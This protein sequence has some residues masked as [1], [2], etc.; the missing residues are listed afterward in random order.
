MP[1]DFS[2]IKKIT[3]PEGD[4]KS[5]SV[6]GVVIWE[7]ASAKVLSSITLSGQTTS[8]NRGQSFVFGGTVTAHYSDSSTADVTSETTFSG[9]NM[10]T[11]GTYT[12]TASYT[13]D[14]VTKT[15]TYSLTVNKAWSTLWSGSKKI[16]NN[17]GS[18]SGASS[19]FCSTASGTGTGPRVRIT[20]SETH[21]GSGSTTYVK[22]GAVVSKPGSPLDF[23][24]MYTSN[25]LIVLGVNQYKTDAGNVKV[26]LVKT[27][28]SNNVSFSLSGETGS[29]SVTSTSCS[30]TIT[31]IEQYY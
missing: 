4:V 9:Y 6:G 23:N 21:S 18:I 2:Q 1:I 28:N 15:A 8:R 17:A 20:W 14:G 3:I 25:N 16:T 10:N 30:L 29:G 7:E 31:K 11:A 5:I 13:E 22:Q 12:V 27:N 19:N 24:T 26:R